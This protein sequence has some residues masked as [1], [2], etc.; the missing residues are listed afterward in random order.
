[1]KTFAIIFIIFILALAGI[2]V[3]HVYDNKKTISIKTD[4]TTSVSENIDDP[5]I[6]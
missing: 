5:T 4:S 1:M 3:H 2:E 6:N